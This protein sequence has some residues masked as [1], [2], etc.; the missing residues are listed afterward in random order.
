MLHFR[1]RLCQCGG[2]YVELPGKRG[3]RGQPPVLSYI[4]VRLPKIPIRD[5]IFLLNHGM[6]SVLMQI[7]IS[8]THCVGK[9]TLVDDV[10]ER[11]PHWE[12]IAEPYYVLEEEGYDFGDVPT[13]E[14]FEAQLTR[15]LQLVRERRHNVIL[16]RCPLDFVAYALCLADSESFN[17]RVWLP[18]LRETVS[19]LDLIVFLPM[20]HR[21]PVPLSE[22]DDFRIAVDEKLREILLD[23]MFDLEMVVLEITGTKAERVQQVV[24]RLSHRKV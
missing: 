4:I 11:L 1:K 14:D 10:I 19:A 16:D 20:E 18:Q 3:L 23:N 7:A 12:S 2:R 6:P 13:L 9:S 5:L 21:I 8:G 17:V 22:D 15:S 24:E